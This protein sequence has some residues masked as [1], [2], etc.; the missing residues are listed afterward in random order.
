MKPA[1]DRS[2]RIDGAPVTTV[3]FR[4]DGRPVSGRAGESI[5]T[6]LWAAGIR[7]LGHSPTRGTPRGMF[8]AVGVCQE[9]VVLVDG[10]RQ[11]ACTTQIAAG[12]DVTSVPRAADAAPS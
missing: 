1:A 8:C 11:P 6:A 5:A 2:L 12:L 3:D 4:F 10:R 9:C 7:T